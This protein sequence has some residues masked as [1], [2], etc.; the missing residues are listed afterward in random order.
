MTKRI[1]IFGATGSIGQNALNLL[2][3]AG[4]AAFRVVALTG[5]QN[6]AQLARDAI[7]FGAEIAVTAD[8]ARYDDLKQLLSGSGVQAA[9]GTDALV[10]AA[11]RPTDIMVSAIVG[12]AGLRPGLAALPHTSRV[13]LANKETLVCAG[14]LFMAELTRTGAQALP[15]DSEHSAIFQALMGEDISQVETVVITA[16]GRAFRDLPMHALQTVT[17]EQA[18]THPNWNMGQRIT[19][20]SASMFNKAMELIEAKEFFGFAP[21]QLRAVIHPQSLVHALVGFCDGAFMAHVG[22]PD[23]RHAIG[24]ALNYPNRADLPVARLNWDAAMTFNFEPACDTR[25]PALRLAGAVMEQGG[26]W[27]AAFNAAKEVAL[28]RFIAHD[29]PFLGMAPLV[30]QVL[31]KL[32][33]QN[34]LSMAADTL[35][36]VLQVDELARVIAAQ[37]KLAQIKLG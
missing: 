8:A 30:E 9:A 12:A 31:D 34:A 36:A 25:Y 1:S 16:S 18:A 21:D 35:D 24:F 28:D 5:A 33:G 13:A 29:I 27:G 23:M 10:D 37:I 20:D 3:H 6:V 17:P 7:E 2:R 15:V 26:L 4:P 19:I 32:D 22:P 11:T 14:P